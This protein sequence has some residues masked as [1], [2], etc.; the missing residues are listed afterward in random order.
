MKSARCAV[1]NARHTQRES[2]TCKYAHGRREHTHIEREREP[3]RAAH[4]YMHMERESNTRAL[5]WFY[6]NAYMMVCWHTPAGTVC[7]LDELGLS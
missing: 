3:E 4:A 5:V 6:T 2:S 7:E 1:G